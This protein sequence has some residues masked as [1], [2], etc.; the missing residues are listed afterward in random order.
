MRISPSRLDFLTRHNPDT[1][2]DCLTQA[3]ALKNHSPGPPD[4]ILFQKKI[5][6]QGGI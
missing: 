5:L 2:L 4:Y 1:P 6:A 3:E